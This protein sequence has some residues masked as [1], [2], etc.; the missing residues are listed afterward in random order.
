MGIRLL[1]TDRIKVIQKE[2][3]GGEEASREC[4][5]CHS[6]RNWK[7][8]IRE[9]NFVAVQRFVCR[10]CGFRF[11]EKSK[12]E[13]Q[14][15]RGCQLS[16]ILKEAKKL[17]TATE[18]KTVAGEIGKTQQEIKGKIVQFAIALKNKGRTPETIRTYIAALYTLSNKGSNLLNPTS[19]E[20]VIAKQDNWTIRAKRNYV[21]WYSRFAKFLHLEWEKPNYKAPSKTPFIPLESEIDQLISGSSKKVS[22]ALHI[23]KETAARIGEILRLKWIDINLQANIIAI[24]EPK[25]GSNCGE[26]QSL[27]RTH[28]PN[29]DVT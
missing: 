7:D 12:I 20:E 8:G 23:A 10:D 3:Q 5:N 22:I 16:A 13:S 6:E 25:K 9:T 21:D 27:K 26:V 1:E 18:I 28:K 4:P 17:G 14:M 24:N 19:V 15:N 29:P 2:Q 11:S